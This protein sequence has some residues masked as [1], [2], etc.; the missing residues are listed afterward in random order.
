MHR[1]TSFWN[2]ALVQLKNSTSVLICKYKSCNLNY[3]ICL[4][5]KIYF[6]NNNVF[7]LYTAFHHYAYSAPILSFRW[8]I[9]AAIYK[10]VW[11]SHLSG[12]WRHGYFCL[13]VILA[14]LYCF[15]NKSFQFSGLSVAHFFR[16]RLLLV[17]ALRITFKG[18][19]PALMY[20]LYILDFC[21]I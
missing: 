11:L 8:K 6:I 15:A 4:T 10:I 19:Y 12:N 9:L 3:S 13:N 16:W 7:I 18:P 1:S 14:I 5:F 20:V 21:L 17:R 2:K